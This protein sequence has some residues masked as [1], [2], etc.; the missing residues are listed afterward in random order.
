MHKFIE[1]CCSEC[2]HGKKTPCEK[3]VE[4]RLE[5]PLCHEN[6]QCRAARRAIIDRYAHSPFFREH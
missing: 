5:G 4:C 6:E 2:T 1:P 3:F